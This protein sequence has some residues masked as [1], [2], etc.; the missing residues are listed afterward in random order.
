MQFQKVNGCWVG[1]EIP[2]PKPGQEIVDLKR[3]LAASKASHAKTIV[4]LNKK[5]QKIQNLRNLLDKCT[6]LARTQTTRLQT[7]IIQ[8]QT[9]LI[10]YTR[11]TECAICLDTINKDLDPVFMCFQ[12]M[13]CIHM[14]CSSQWFKQRGQCPTCRSSI[15]YFDA[16][17][18]AWERT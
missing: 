6:E 10:K 4:K 2:E 18:T 7:T 5:H 15:T 16:T 1:G 17:N 14:T 3:E 9:L 13:N 12:C 8:L 11:N